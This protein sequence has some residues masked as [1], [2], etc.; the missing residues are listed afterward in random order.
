MRIRSKELRKA[1]KVKQENYKIRQKEAA[2]K[3]K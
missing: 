1:R 3:K 2:A